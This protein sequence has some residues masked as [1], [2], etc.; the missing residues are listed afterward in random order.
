MSATHARIAPALVAALMAALATPAGAQTLPPTGSDN[1]YARIVG[2]DSRDFVQRFRALQA[3]TAR[4]PKGDPQAIPALIKAA[5]YRTVHDFF[6]TER[7]R[8]EL[9]AASGMNTSY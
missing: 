4:P 9:G 1:V 7:V 3:L 8:S 2:D 6:G 5:R